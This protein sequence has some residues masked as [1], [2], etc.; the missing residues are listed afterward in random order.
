MLIS[1]G[2][3]PL[4]QNYNYG[5]RKVEGKGGTLKGGGNAIERTLLLKQ[6]AR[7]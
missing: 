6:Q 3:K 2:S 4:E 5:C 7:S 1:H